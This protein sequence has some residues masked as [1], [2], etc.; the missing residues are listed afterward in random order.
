MVCVYCGNDTQVTNSRLQKRNNAVWRRRTCKECS[1]TITTLERIDLETAVMV[2]DESVHTPFSRDKLFISI[3]NSCKHR[4]S[5]QADASGLT[6]TIISRLYPH[7]SDA[8]I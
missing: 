4:K 2:V 6:D 7:I 1:A 3:Y 8:S 5:A